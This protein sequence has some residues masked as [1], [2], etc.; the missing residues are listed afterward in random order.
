M[1][2]IEIQSTIIVKAKFIGGLWYVSVIDENNYIYTVNFSGEGTEDD[3]FI[4]NS[5]YTALLEVK[6][7]VPPPPFKEKVNESVLGT[8][9]TER[10][11]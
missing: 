3:L 7:I 1:T 4:S 6:K 2:N 10:R 5:T 8:T 11:K 9:P